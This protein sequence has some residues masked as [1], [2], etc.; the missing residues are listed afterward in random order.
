MPSDVVNQA[1]AKEEV[2]PVDPSSAAVSQEPSA[3]P[4]MSMDTA[5]L[6][7]GEEA[8][9]NFCCCGCDEQCC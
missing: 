9:C 7:G 2:L 5:R 1:P 6:R 8:S 3:E 4:Q